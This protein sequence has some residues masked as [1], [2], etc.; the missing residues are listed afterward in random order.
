MEE[1]KGEVVNTR[2]RGR[3]KIHESILNG[4][5]YQPYNYLQSLVADLENSQN[6]C[7]MLEKTNI[8]LDQEPVNRIFKTS[9]NKFIHKTC[10]TKEQ[11][12]FSYHIFRFKCRQMHLHGKYYDL[13]IQLSQLVF[14]KKCS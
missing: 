14:E 7:A 8:P 1:G 3:G 12:K 9:G 5:D 2:I 4:D 13:T 10:F 11:K 6:I